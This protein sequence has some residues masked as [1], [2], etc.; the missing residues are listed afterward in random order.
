MAKVLSKRVII[1]VIMTFLGFLGGACTGYI[2]ASFQ[3]MEVM[4]DRMLEAIEGDI[5][6]NYQILKLIDDKKVS[7]LVEQLEADLLG[8]LEVY[9]LLKESFGRTRMKY[10]RRFSEIEKKLKNRHV[11][12]EETGADRVTHEK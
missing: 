1:I 3:G 7:V 10:D 6:E 5:L 2:Y 12:T 8:H 9:A 4:A 11:P